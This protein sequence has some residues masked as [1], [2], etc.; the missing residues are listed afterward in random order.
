MLTEPAVI[1]VR[2][3]RIEA[4]SSAARAQVPAG[5]ERVDLAGRIVVP[6]LINSHG[7]V[8]G[9]R[10]L[11]SN[12]ELYT[13]ENVLVQLRLYARYGITT[14][15]SLGGDREAGFAVR[16]EQ[17]ERPPGRARLFVAGPVIEARNPAEARARVDELAA[18]RPDI[19]KIRVDDQLGTTEKMQPEIY[20]AVIERAHKRGLKVAVHIFYLDDA[21]GVLRAGADFIAHSIRDKPVDDQLIEL[22]KARDVCVCPTLTREV[23][24]FVYESEPSFFSDPF[25]LRHADPDV[26]NRLRDPARQQSVHESKAAQQ[27]K[28]ALE[29]A[30]R[31]LTMLLARGVR[32]AFGTDS[33]PP[34]RFQGYF[35][36]LELELM[37]KAGMTGR[38]I[39]RAATTDAAG[40]LGLQRLGSLEPG[41]WA[42]FIVVAESPL[43]DVRK[44][45]G[46]E[47]VWI[48]GERVEAR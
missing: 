40:C 7:H 33:G 11:E 38:Q 36:H 6:G 31:N 44:L 47:S 4:V 18:M 26:L 28:V 37:A 12:P 8:G 3:G 48:G 21:K 35:E 25:F 10:G 20:S 45:R 30:N 23:S 2:D 34:G 17:N 9:T 5:S 39:L 32:V 24:T 1:V 15:M 13:R 43:D 27:Y 22:L 14:V 41:T 29:V 16:D 46:I 42:D 19:L